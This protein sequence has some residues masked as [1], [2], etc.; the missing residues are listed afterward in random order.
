MRKKSLLCIHEL[1]KELENFETNNMIIGST[2]YISNH[3]LPD[4]LL[5]IQEKHSNVKVQIYTGLS[6]EVLDKVV[7]YEYHLAVIGRLPYPDNIVFIPLLKTKLLFISKDDM[8]ERVSLEE[9]VNYPIILP[10]HG[11]ATRDYLMGAIRCEKSDHHQYHQL[12]KSTGD[13]AYGPT[14]DGWRILS[15]LQ[16]PA[17]GSGRTVPHG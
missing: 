1:K 17:G 7:D 11:S 14:G 2:P 12:R 4:V 5:A 10:E 3:V 6:Q 15:P 13:P 9:L 16:H 8:G